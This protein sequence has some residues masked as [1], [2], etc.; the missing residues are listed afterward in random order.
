MAQVCSA[1]VE[2]PFAVVRVYKCLF[3]RFVSSAPEILM[4]YSI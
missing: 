2:A 3:D 1:A 4:L